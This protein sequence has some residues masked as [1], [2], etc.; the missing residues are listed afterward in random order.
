[1]RNRI[2]KEKY[3]AGFMYREK[4][5]RSRT[6]KGFATWWF[7]IEGEETVQVAIIDEYGKAAKQALELAKGR[8]VWLLP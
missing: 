8:P 3:E 5:Y 2:R 6:P 7:E 1:M 4:G